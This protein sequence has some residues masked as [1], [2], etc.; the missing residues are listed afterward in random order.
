MLNPVGWK[1]NSPTRSSDDE[2]ATLQAASPAIWEDCPWLAIQE[3]PALGR[4][5]F[6][7]FT[8]LPLAGTQTTQIGFG[9]Y[10]VFNTGSGTVS[11]VSA[12]NSA[13]V[14]GGALSIALDTDNDSG[15]LAQAY[16][17]FRLSG[18]K[19]TSGKLWCEF[20]YAQNSI[21]TNMAA[22]F[23]GLAETELWTLATGV[24]FNGGDAIT[25]SASAIGFRIE[26]DG[27]GVIDT[28]YSDRAT[29]FTNIGDTE[30]GT[31]A[32]NTFRNLGFV[33]DPNESERCIRFF[34]NN[35]E[36]TTAVSK[37]TLTGLTNLDA[38]ALGLIIACCADT[39]GTS[40]AGYLKSWRVA[41]LAPGVAV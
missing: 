26:E 37:T 8:G 28:V 41:Q 39:G 27:L 1:R 6:D 17:S 35:V 5:F 33:Y 24:P 15:S 34:A 11:R 14:F 9:Q 16:P 23:M 20:V 7:D 36:L 10:K 30:G 25:N 31:L 19:S 13:E 21:A 2:F 32:A 40:F 22:V 12:V 29:S 18:D 4:V 3:N 38:N